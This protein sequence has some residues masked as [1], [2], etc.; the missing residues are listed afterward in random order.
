MPSLRAPL[1]A[2][3][4]LIAAAPASA[5]RNRLDRRDPL[6]EGARK[7]VPAVAGKPAPDFTVTLLDGKTKRTLSKLYVDKPVFL[8]FGS[9]T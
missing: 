3:L 4:L 6:P 9:Y 2:L 5:Q 1:A 7:A 8:V